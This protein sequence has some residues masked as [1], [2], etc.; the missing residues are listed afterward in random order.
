MFKNN[1]KQ[2]VSILKHD[3]QLKINYQILQDNKIIKKENGSF[4][5][6]NN[7]LPKDAGY[8]ID[9]LQKD[10]S[11][12]YLITLCED[13]DQILTQQSE[14]QQDI[15]KISLNNTYDITIPKENIKNSSGYF[16]DTGIDYILSPYTLLYENIKEY[17]NTNSLNILL[18]NNKIYIL[19]INNQKEIVYSVIKALTPFENIQ[20]SDF[21][22]DD[23]VGKKLYEEV[24][25]LELQQT[26]LDIIDEYYKS[27]EGIEFLESINLY[28]TVKQL[29]DESL[30]TLY[31]AT[32]IDV[33]YYNID[34]DKIID[35][36]ITKKQLDKYSFIKPRVKKKD[37]NLALWMGLSVATLLVLGGTLYYKKVDQEN[38]I[39]IQEK[40][41][42]KIA[43]E[44]K[45]QQQIIKQQVVKIPNHIKL[46]NNIIE[47]VTMFFDIVPYDAVLLELSMKK[48]SSTFVSNFIL[49]SNSTK[50]MQKQLLNIYNE[51][52]IILQHK[53]NTIV[54]TI[55]ENNGYKQQDKKIDNIK[56]QEY[57]FISIAKFTKYL[58]TIIKEN[59]TLKYISKNRSE[60]LTYTYNVKSLY[61]TPQEFFRFI[62]KLNKKDIS[63]NIL[64]PIEFAK[65]KDKIEVKY[66]IEFHQ[67]NKKTYTTK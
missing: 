31:D 47:R 20:N 3:K 25:F 41:Q 12:T 65:I 48:D 38:Q 49:D 62:E 35:D 16:K 7:E 37:N 1:K 14:T 42:A 9:I 26:I 56:Y 24:Y 2:Y 66:N 30:T 17:L 64:Y 36:M 8:K 29:S 45:K 43:K 57:K 18:L 39:L 58:K 21:Y 50:E 28:Y 44:K 54:S 10:I 6:N 51:S 11:Y 59:S 27:G 34:F 32:M 60:Y 61:N 63:I 40:Q 67:K 46:N 15:D 53:N 4:L 13:E 19:I 22:S 55:I 33:N 5:I 23:T 52:K